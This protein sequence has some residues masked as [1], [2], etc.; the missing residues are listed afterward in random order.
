MTLVC[1]KSDS[2]RKD[3][4]HAVWALGSI[5]P[6]AKA[7]IPVLIDMLMDKNWDLRRQA[8][9]ALQRIGFVEE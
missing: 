7:S 9:N 5:G 1:S 2:W 8:F 6:R 4:S 3:R